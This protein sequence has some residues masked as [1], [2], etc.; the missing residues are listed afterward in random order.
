MDHDRS[1]S[2]TSGI[3]DDPDEKII[4]AKFQEIDEALAQIKLETSHDL[5]RFNAIKK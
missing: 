3:N 4:N 1:K 2:R 5:Q